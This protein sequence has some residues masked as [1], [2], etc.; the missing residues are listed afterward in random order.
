MGCGCQEHMANSTFMHFNNDRKVFWYEIPRNA[1]T[2]VKKNVPGME[3]YRENRCTPDSGQQWARKNGFRQF[4]IIRDPFMRLLS[5][6]E[7]FERLPARSYEVFGS[8]TRMSYDTFVSR[9]SFHHDH[10]CEPQTTFLP[11]DLSDINLIRLESFQ[12]EWCDFF[13]SQLILPSVKQWGSTAGSRSLNSL[14]NEET[15]K[16]ILKL[17]KN[18][19]EALGYSKELQC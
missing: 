9:L 5:M 8:K 15:L 10:H 13:S 11:N 4:A 19:F 14:R 2:S 1:S 7:V 6:L 3:E 12:K 18:D 16:M 17:Y